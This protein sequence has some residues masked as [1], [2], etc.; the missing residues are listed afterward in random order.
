[1]DGSLCCI[2]G[3]RNDVA[4]FCC[5]LPL[6]ARSHLRGS[7]DRPPFARGQLLRSYVPTLAAAKT[8]NRFIPLQLAIRNISITFVPQVFYCRHATIFVPPLIHE[9]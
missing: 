6:V 2:L 8:G 1:M 7:R 9:K 3:L 4:L 5:Y